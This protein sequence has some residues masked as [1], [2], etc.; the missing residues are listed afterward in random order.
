MRKII[1]VFSE[2]NSNLISRVYWYKQIIPSSKSK[3]VLFEQNK[4]L[5]CF[6][7]EIVFLSVLFIF[8]LSHLT[9]L[10]DRHI[11]ELLSFDRIRIKLIWTTDT[12]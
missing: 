2:V 6:P 9:Q 7:C 5:M 3:N 11:H 12:Y 1:T 10:H 8:T 4:K